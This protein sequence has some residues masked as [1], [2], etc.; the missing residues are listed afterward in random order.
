[1]GVACDRTSLL[2]ACVAEAVRLRAPG[3]AV[4]MAACNLA[5][6]AGHHTTVHVHKVRSQRSVTHPCLVKT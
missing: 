2:A 5:V 6:P 1:M 3:I 4:R